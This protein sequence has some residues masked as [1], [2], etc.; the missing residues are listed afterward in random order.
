MK[1]LPH[2]HP[3]EAQFLS[4]INTGHTSSVLERLPL[5][6]HTLLFLAKEN[7]FDQGQIII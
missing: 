4:L 7:L 1:M 5:E 2:C 3:V 6:A